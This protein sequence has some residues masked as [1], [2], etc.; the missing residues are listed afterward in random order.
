MDI[1]SAEINQVK[2]AKSLKIELAGI[3]QHPR[4]WTAETPN[5]YTLV[6]TVHNTPPKNPENPLK[7]PLKNPENPEKLF[8][9]DT[10]SCRVGIRNI[11]INSSENN[12]VLSINGNAIRIAGVNRHEFDPEYGRSIDEI[13]MQND[14]KLL[15][16][17]NFNAVRCSHYPAHP[18][19][20]EICD[21]VGIYVVDEANIESHGFQ[22]LGQPVGYLSHLPEWRSA[23][24]SRVTRMYERDKNCASVIIWSLGNESG[25]GPTHLEM[26][27]WLRTRDPTRLVQV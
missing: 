25:C 22:T 13:S 14:V 16:K 8:P 4:L 18:R 5:L 26:A 15:K 7:K 24:F 3:I 17:L 2:P 11:S 9:I 23:L 19:W 27:S 1:Y 12:N 10:E 6:L 20:L 21:E